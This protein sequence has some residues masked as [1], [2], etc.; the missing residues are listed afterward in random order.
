MQ[1][2]PLAQPPVTTSSLVQRL[3]V[4]S[5]ATKLISH[6]GLGGILIPTLGFWLPVTTPFHQRI[7]QWWLKRTC[8]ILS[9]EVRVQGQLPSEAGLFVSNH[10]SWMDIIVIGGQTPI[11]FLSKA[12]VRRWPIIGWFAACTGTLFIQRGNGKSSAMASTIQ[13]ALSKGESILV[14]PEATSTD[15][16]QV[17]RFFPNMFSAP[18]QAHTPVHPL[19]IRYTERGVLSTNA[20][21]I[22]DDEFFSHL[23]NI[24]TLDHITVTLHALN[25]IPTTTDS[26]R[27]SISD[28]AREQINTTITLP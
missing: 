20:P 15:G 8:D 6:I 10:V 5:K 24:L 1:E 12:E 17:R 28:Q 2:S 26:K 9:L 25:P 19:A 14:F 13:T 27:K 7:T 4:V 23:I 18:I 16:Q 22:D 21:F 3:R 11:R